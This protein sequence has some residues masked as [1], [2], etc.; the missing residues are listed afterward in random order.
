[1]RNTLPEGLGSIRSG[2]L[3]QPQPLLF[4]CCFYW[5]L[6]ESLTMGEDIVLVLRNFWEV[7]CFQ[8]CSDCFRGVFVCTYTCMLTGWGKNTKG[9][10]CGTLVMHA[11]LLASIT[12]GNLDTDS[13]RTSFCERGS[14]DLYVRRAKV[15]KC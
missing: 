1:M 10:W 15:K 3:L 14:W 13:S 5:R 7:S 4:Y 9:A 2:S 12:H 8:Y 6:I 11:M